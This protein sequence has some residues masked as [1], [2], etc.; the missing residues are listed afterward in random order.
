MHD[1]V[2]GGLLQLTLTWL[3]VPWPSLGLTLPIAILSGKI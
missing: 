1:A 2:S 3:L